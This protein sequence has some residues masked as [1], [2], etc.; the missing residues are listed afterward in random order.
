MLSDSRDLFFT[1]FARLQAAIASNLRTVKRIPQQLTNLWWSL[2]LSVFLLISHDGRAA[3]KGIP[4]AEVELIS[5]LFDRGC[6][7]HR[8]DELVSFE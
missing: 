7:Q 8:V 3:Q 4:D 6:N 5:L 2:G 1:F